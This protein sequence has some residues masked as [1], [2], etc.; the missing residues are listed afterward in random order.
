MAE[1]SDVD[2]PSVDGEGVYL[3]ALVRLFDRNDAVLRVDVAYGE[4]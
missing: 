4:R 3:G 1:S 2:K